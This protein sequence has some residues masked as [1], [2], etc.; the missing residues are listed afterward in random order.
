MIQLILCNLN[1]V[2]FLEVYIE[3]IPIFMWLT[4][5]SQ[6]V[7]RICHPNKEVQSTLFTLIVKLIKAY[8]QHCLWMMASIFNVI[9]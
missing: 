8:P 9:L 4:A 1:Y 6:L 2:Y 7:S 5:F 3:K